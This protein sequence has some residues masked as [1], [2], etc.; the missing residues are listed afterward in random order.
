MDAL[1]HMRGFLTSRPQRFASEHEAIQWSIRSG[2]V[3]NEESATVS[4]PAQLFS[5]DGGEG[6][7]EWRT[8]L[9][10]SEPYWQ[11]TLHYVLACMHI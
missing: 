3:R 6:W 9:L 10:A 8:N 4:I 5:T 1:T 2:Q 7:V 11:G